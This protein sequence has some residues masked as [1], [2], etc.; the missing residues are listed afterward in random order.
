MDHP[1]GDIVVPEREQTSVYV[2]TEDA[3]L[4]KLVEGFS[5][6]VHRVLVKS[7]EDPEKYCIVTQSDFLKFFYDNRDHLDQDIL[8]SLVKYDVDQDMPEIYRMYTISTA[9]TGF[10]AVKLMSK[11]GLNA[12]AVTH[13]KTNEVVT[14]LSA[15]D[16]KNIDFDHCWYYPTSNS[17]SR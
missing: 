12:V 9:Q 2:V 13:Q 17:S 7:S 15:S 4:N 6:G 14:T 1:V 11:L 10:D 8:T 16:M 5:F 3:T